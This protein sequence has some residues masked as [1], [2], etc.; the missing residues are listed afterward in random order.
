MP[1]KTK[2]AAAKT[3]IGQPSSVLTDQFFQAVQG[4]EPDD[5]VLPFSGPGQLPT[6]E[7]VVKLFFFF[8]EQVGLQNSNFTRIALPREYLL[9]L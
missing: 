4:N 8:K 9:M 3:L 5:D 7:Q 1:P 2:P 6:A